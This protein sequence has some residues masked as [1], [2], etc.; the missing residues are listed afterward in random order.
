MLFKRDFPILI[1]DGLCFSGAELLV[2]F[3]RVHYEGGGGGGGD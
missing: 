3:G 2:E 1:S